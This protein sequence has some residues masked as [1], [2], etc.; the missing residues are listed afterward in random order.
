MGGDDEVQ[1]A[2][3]ELLGLHKW[4]G[5]VAGCCGKKQ[6]ETSKTI[7]ASTQ[8][9]N[10]EFSSGMFEASALE[11]GAFSWDKATSLDVQARWPEEL[12]NIVRPN[13]TSLLCLDYVAQCFQNVWIWAMHVE[14][15]QGAV[16]TS[17]L[18][19]I[20]YLGSIAPWQLGATW[21]YFFASVWGTAA[22]D[23]AKAIT[24]VDDDLILVALDHGSTNGTFI[25]KSRLEKVPWCRVESHD[26]R[27]WKTY[28]VPVQ[29]LFSLSCNLHFGIS[30]FD[31]DCH[32]PLCQPWAVLRELVWRWKW[33]TSS[34]WSLVNVTLIEIG[35]IIFRERFP[36]NPALISSKFVEVRW[37]RLQIP[38]QRTGGKFGWKAQGTESA[39]PPLET[40]IRRDRHYQLYLITIFHVF[41]GL[42]MPI[43]WQFLV[44]VRGIV[45]NCQTVVISLGGPSI[46]QFHFVFLWTCVET[47]YI[48]S[49]FIVHNIT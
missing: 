7:P 36:H 9:S 23:A 26:A 41:H 14:N 15:C 27:I 10:P 31:A 37:K 8:N 33:R 22:W 24:Q 34:I 42:Y 29:P 17:R 21:T 19:T 30:L 35:N 4:M 40:N 49:I 45:Q 28:E 39:G 1:C 16:S 13:S 2:L 47:I 18:S 11:S 44:S 25:N 38:G 48:D 12:L 20:L 6:S 3:V 32:L 5:R 46:I 43:L